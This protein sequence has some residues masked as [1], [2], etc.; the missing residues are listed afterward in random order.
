MLYFGIYKDVVLPVVSKEEIPEFILIIR[1]IGESIQ[2]E[3]A[4]E[5]RANNESIEDNTEYN[6]IISSI[7]IDSALAEITNA[8]EKGDETLAKEKAEAR[9]GEKNLDYDKYLGYVVAAYFGQRKF[10]KAAETVLIRN[11]SRTAWNYELKI[12]LAKCIRF[13]T[14][15]HTLN[16]GVELVASLLKKYKDPLLSY[17]WTCIPLE[18]LEWIENGVYCSDINNT[19]NGNLKFKKEVKYITQKYPQDPFVYYG[20][21][22]LGDFDKALKV[23][24]NRIENLCL[25]AYGFQ[26]VKDIQRK[27]NML[28]YKDS[29]NHSLASQDKYFPYKNFSS[30][31]NTGIKYFMQYVQKYS[32]EDQADDAA[33]WLGW[34][35]AMSGRYKDSIGWL[36]YGFTVG[37]GDYDYINKEFRGDLSQKRA[38]G[39]DNVQ[40]LTKIP[41]RNQVSDEID[42]S[43]G[44][45]EGY[46]DDVYFGYYNH[47]TR[48]DLLKEIKKSASDITRLYSYLYYLADKGQVEKA[49]DLYVDI[50]NCDKNFRNIIKND[51]DN[52]FSEN[53]KINNINTPIKTIVSTI[54]KNK[55][56]KKDNIWLRRRVALSQINSVLKN[57]LLSK[58]EQEYLL[59]LKTRI[60][61]ITD[62]SSVNS[63]VNYFISKYP[64]SDLVDDMIAEGIYTDLHILKFTDRALKSIEYLLKYYPGSNACDNAINAVG[65]YYQNYVS[66]YYP[67]WKDNC[68]L[69]IKFNSLILNKYPVSS[70][71]KHA[72]ERVNE[73]NDFLSQN[74]TYKKYTD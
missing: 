13:Y 23:N 58:S 69:A 22:L 15:D 47:C 72:T 21:F 63:M 67:D 17:M 7:K 32:K 48:S 38:I 40:S 68:N 62:P 56:E 70:Y 52:I 42:Y 34:L 26:K 36:N 64:K 59:Y 3:D 24:D 61:V 27:M 18:V 65:S 46:I 14:L 49:T 29:A 2:K 30:D 35:H 54:L 1:A 71:R 10:D 44:D 60:L 33:F 41:K 20:Y 5:K 16:E 11:K 50:K 8:F 43:G 51:Y 74:K 6:S 12:D 9:F 28:G 73:C 4:W 19:I 55:N 37:N 53:V 66:Y 45:D 31:V 25:Y 57:R 39:F